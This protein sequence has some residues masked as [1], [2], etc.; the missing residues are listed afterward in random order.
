MNFSEHDLGGL[1]VNT[2]AFATFRPSLK[3]EFQ[4][5]YMCQIYYIPCAAVLAKPTCI[6]LLGVC[7][8]RDDLSIA[9]RPLFDALNPGCGAP[10]GGEVRQYSKEC[11]RL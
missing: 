9:S 10:L 3:D 7:R 4:I 1:S 5:D 6:T 8:C 2:E 11:H